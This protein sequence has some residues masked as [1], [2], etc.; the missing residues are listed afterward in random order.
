MKSM[1][2]DFSAFASELALDKQ[3]VSVGG[4]FQSEQLANAL[5]A[6]T[7]FVGRLLVALLKQVG[8]FLLV[9]LNAAMGAHVAC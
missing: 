1:C 4:P 8:I 2:E 7:D 3:P 9:L 6:T 5:V